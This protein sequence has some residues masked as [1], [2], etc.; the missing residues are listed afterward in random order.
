MQAVALDPVVI[1][2]SDRHGSFGAVV[3]SWHRAFSAHQWKVARVTVSLAILIPAM[4]PD[5]LRPLVEN[6]L[7]TCGLPLEIHVA[8]TG[9]LFAAANLPKPVKKYVDGGD[10]WGNRLNYMC[11]HTDAEYVFCGADDVWFHSG[12]AQAAIAAQESIGGGVVTVNDLISDFGTLPL[13][14]QNYLREFGAGTVD[15]TGLIIH[16]GY[17]H[18]FSERELIYTATAR[19]RYAYCPESIVEHHHWMAGKADRNDP[20]YQLGELHW[21]E[22]IALYS[23]REHLWKTL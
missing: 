9:P 6:I 21:D 11:E 15:R 13:V 1:P 19:G 20:V 16:R 8:G 3:L 22:D 2:C 7:L 5:K 17:F 12:W 18:N 10:T 14:A 23:S 4:R